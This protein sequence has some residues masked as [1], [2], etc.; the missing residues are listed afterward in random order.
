M[1]EADAGL[2]ELGQEGRRLALVAV[3]THALRSKRVDQDEQ[4]V[5]VVAFRE[6]FDLGETAD[7][8]LVRLG[9]DDVD[10][11]VEI[12]RNGDEADQD[13]GPERPRGL[14]FLH[15]AEDYPIEPLAGTEPVQICV[16]PL[17]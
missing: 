13:D 7:G 14:A 6:G 9:D 3:D 5:R 1:T 10:R 15:G 2:R 17:L 8:S 4:D 16:G 12:D 11:A